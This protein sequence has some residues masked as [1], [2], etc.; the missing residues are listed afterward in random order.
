MKITKISSLLMRSMKLVASM[1]D[2]RK[3]DFD[4]ARESF[5][6]KT[7]ATMM[8]SGRR[9][10]CMAG[11]SCTMRVGSLLMRAIGLMISFMAM[12]KYIMIILLYY[13]AD[14]ITRISIF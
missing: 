10:R 9:I 1:K 12:A 2:L 13:K 11:A 6:I 3:M 5:T 14:S 8:A 4:M 7:A